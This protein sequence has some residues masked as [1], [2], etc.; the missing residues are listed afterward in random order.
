MAEAKRARRAVSRVAGWKPRTIGLI[1]LFWPGFVLAL[2][3][4]AVSTSY[5]AHGSLEA[6]RESFTESNGV[7]LGF[8]VLAPPSCLTV[9]WWRVRRRRR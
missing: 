3:G 4:A 2:I 1:W 6:A 8:A 7:M 5:L 9:I